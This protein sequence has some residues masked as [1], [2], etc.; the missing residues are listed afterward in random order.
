MFLRAE[1]AP[2]PTA[3]NGTTLGMYTPDLPALREQLFAPGIKVPPIGYLQDMP[4]GE[5]QVSDPDGNC[6]VISHWEKSSRKP[7]RNGSAE[8]HS[9]NGCPA[10]ACLEHVAGVATFWQCSILPPS[11]SLSP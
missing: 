8:K 3:S 4:S 2:D 1:H 9:R 5:M 10:G 11:S 7:A 6:I